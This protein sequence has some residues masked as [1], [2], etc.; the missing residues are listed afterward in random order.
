MSMLVL[1]SNHWTSGSLGCFLLFVFLSF[2]SPLLGG[3]GDEQLSK[4]ITDY[5][6]YY[7]IKAGMNFKVCLT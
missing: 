2:F 6:C 3:G 4:I 5:Q 7:C 1:L